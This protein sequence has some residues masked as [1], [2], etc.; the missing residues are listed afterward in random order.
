MGTDEVS[1]CS[2]SVLIGNEI[3]HCVRGAGFSWDGS[4]DRLQKTNTQLSSAELVH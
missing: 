3:K 4:G 1:D 2:W